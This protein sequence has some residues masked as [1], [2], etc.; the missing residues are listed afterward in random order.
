MPLTFTPLPKFLSFTPVMIW[1]KFSWL[2]CRQP[3]SLR[4]MAIFWYLP[5][6]LYQK[7]KN[8][9]VNLTTITPSKEA[10]ELAARSEKDPRLVN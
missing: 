6:K 7:P 3:G 1:L 10:L 9:L 4:K 5:K 2:P 8:R